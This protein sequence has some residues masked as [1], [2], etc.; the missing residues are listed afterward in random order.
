MKL[1]SIKFC[2]ELKVKEFNP[3][4]AERVQ[5]KKLMLKLDDKEVYSIV[6]N[7]FKIDG[8]S[9]FGVVPKIIWERMMVPDESNRITLD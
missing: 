1:K 6:D 3:P 8:G 7:S 5:G 4:E 9:M 2:G